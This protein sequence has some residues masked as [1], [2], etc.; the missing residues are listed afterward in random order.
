MRSP[1]DIFAGGARDG[2]YPGGQLAASRD[3]KRLVVASV[4][5]IAPGREPARDDTIY[6]LASLTKPLATSILLG[7]AVEEGKCTFDD[8][9]GRFIPGV[10]VRITLRHLLEHSSGYPA[11]DRFDQ[12]LPPTL[13][14]GTWDAW[15]HIIFKAARTP[16]DAPP[17]A[18]ALYSDLG[19]ILL[20]AALEIMFS[21]PLS[22]AQAFLGTQLF[23]RDTRGP[24]ALPLVP[25]RAPIAPTEGCHPGQV[26]DENTRAMGGAAG[27]AGLFGT[28]LDVLKL[29]E[30]LVHAYHGWKG[31]VLKP[32]TVRQ[33]WTPSRVEGSTRTLGWDRPSATN[34]STGG[35]WPLHSV[36]HLGF[37]GTSAW[38]EPEIG[39]VV[40]LVTNRVCPTRAN[41]MIRRLR[42]LLYDAAW[43][44]WS[45]PRAQ[46]SADATEPEVAAYPSDRSD[47][48]EE[49]KT[50]RIS[51]EQM[52]KMRTKGHLP[53]KGPGS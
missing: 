20:G 28:A 41:N 5:V 11:H 6:D 45:K 15:R 3:G 26:H 7:R 4:G 49:E 47:R 24:P 8:P 12:T 53:S 16:R 34:S 52:A 42:P 27:Q 10:D 14:P 2:V 46:S 33:L 50:V 31:G 43:D 37:T 35:R 38:I 30:Q 17:G 1:I 23:F 36:G 40:V 22:I 19:F 44:A 25:A 29:C 9:V 21:K 13:R 18:R 39:L 32:E 51:L 48:S